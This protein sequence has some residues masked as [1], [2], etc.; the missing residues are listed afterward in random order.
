MQFF[1]SISPVILYGFPKQQIKQLHF[2]GIRNSTK[3]NG[4]YFIY[5]GVLFI[6]PA[7]LKLPV[8]QSYYGAFGSFATTT[9]PLCRN[10]QF[11]SILNP[12]PRP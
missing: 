11:R 3:V 10:L 4:G 2:S 1:L 7:L 6:Y 8:S 12:E 9:F 5:L